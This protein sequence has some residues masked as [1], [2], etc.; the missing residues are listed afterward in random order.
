MRVLKLNKRLQVLSRGGQSSRLH[1]Y[2]IHTVHVYHTTY[3]YHCYHSPFRQV[4]KPKTKNSDTLH[5]ILLSCFPVLPC[6]NFP[7]SCHPSVSDSAWNHCHHDC[8]CQKYVS[9]RGRSPPSPHEPTHHRV[10]HHMTIV[11]VSPELDSG[12]PKKNPPE[13]EYQTSSL[14]TWFPALCG[15]ITTMVGCRVLTA[16]PLLRSALRRIWI[17]PT[18]SWHVSTHLII[19]SWAAPIF[20]TILY[21]TFCNDT[22]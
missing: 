13:T 22:F 7:V 21:F 3:P 19:A 1:L 17:H 12:L 2:I 6:L 5:L 4:Y 10:Y 11:S 8:T 16:L 20:C 18:S 15:G 14:S 9:E